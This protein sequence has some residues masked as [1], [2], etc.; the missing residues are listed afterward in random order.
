MILLESIYHLPFYPNYTTQNYGISK[1]KENI[2]NGC[3][4]QRSVVSER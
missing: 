4:Q 1:H 3:Y 2:N